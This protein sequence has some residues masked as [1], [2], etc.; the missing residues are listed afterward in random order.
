M[1]MTRWK[2]LAPWVLLLILE[3]YLLYMN[4]KYKNFGYEVYTIFK[5]HNA[6]TLDAIIGKKKISC[7]QNQNDITDI[8]HHSRCI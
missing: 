5:N 6:T 4:L 8:F 2:N 3:S 1:F 7:Y